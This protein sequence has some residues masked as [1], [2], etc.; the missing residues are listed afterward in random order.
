MMLQISHLMNTS[1]KVGQTSKQVVGLGPERQ[2]LMYHK[3][4]QA[5]EQMQP[6]DS[7]ALLMVKDANQETQRGK[8]N[9]PQCRNYSFTQTFTACSRPC[10]LSLYSGKKNEFLSKL[11]HH[12]VLGC[13]TSQQS[14]SQLLH[15]FFFFFKGAKVVI[16][17]FF[18]DSKKPANFKIQNT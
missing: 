13:C 9:K 7:A 11:C 18:W 5:G 15:V 3:T 8:E 17:M 14:R 16:F 2:Q 4:N 12:H 6:S 1:L 10:D